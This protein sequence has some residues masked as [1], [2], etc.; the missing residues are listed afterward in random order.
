MRQFISPDIAPQKN[1][2]QVS[3]L[4]TTAD[5][6]RMGRE[7]VLHGPSGRNDQQG[8][9][10]TETAEFEDHVPAENNRIHRRK[11]RRRG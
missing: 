8:Q 6:Y 9:Q 7:Q 2:F 11:L 4:D 3:E 5:G 1:L 10:K